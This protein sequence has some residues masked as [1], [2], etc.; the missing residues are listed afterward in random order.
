MPLLRRIPNTADAS[1]AL[2][3]AFCLAAGGVPAFGQLM[4]NPDWKESDAPPP[5]A[6]NMNRLL[7]VDPPAHMTLRYGI[8]PASI[9][10]T[11]D[12]VVR[13]V[14]V[15][16]SPH[17]AVNAFYEGVRCATGEMKTYARYTG[18]AWHTVSDPDWKRIKDMTSRHTSELASQALCRGQAPRASVD[19]MVRHLKQ[20]IREVE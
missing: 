1:R 16:S 5:P 15:A 14:I 10:V 8:D 9:A 19:D 2:V 11:G 20:P 12:G 7:P 6:F 18:D 4:D 3:L 17:G 13:Y